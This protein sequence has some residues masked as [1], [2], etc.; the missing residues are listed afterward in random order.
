MAAIGVSSVVMLGFALLNVSQ[1]EHVVAAAPG[2]SRLVMPAPMT[3]AG[4]VEPMFRAGIVGGPALISPTTVLVDVPT[5]VPS[6][7][8][9]MLASPRATIIKKEQQLVMV[10][11]MS[12]PLRAGPSTNTRILARMVQGTQVVRTGREQKQRSF[13][14]Y[15][16]VYQ[17]RTGWCRSMYCKQMA[18]VRP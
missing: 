3:T 13:T 1:R 12:E 5:V 7:T 16:V 2:E 14:W 9:P 6:P 8:Q 15:E 4:A 17:G 18:G 11:A 10:R